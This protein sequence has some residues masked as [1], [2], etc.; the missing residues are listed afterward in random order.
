[1]RLICPNCGAQYEVDDAVIPDQGR[2]VQCSNCGHTWFQ[3]PAHKDQ[4]TADELADEVETGLAS[5]PEPEPEIDPAPDA[6]TP[7]Q[8]LDP[9]VAKL[10]RE[11]AA[12]E[13]AARQ[14]DAQSGLETQPDLGLDEAAEAAAARTAAARARMARMRGAEEDPDAPP[15]PTGPRK[16][17]LPDVEEINSSLRASEER[18]APDVSSTFAPSEDP[19]T[20][21]EA[22][23]GG[24]GR[25]LFRTIVVL[26]LIALA[27]Y[28]FAPQIVAQIPQSEPILSQYVDA[29]NGLRAQVD[30]VIAQL[31][32]QVQNLIGGGSSEGAPGTEAPLSE[33]PEPAPAP[34]GE[35]PSQ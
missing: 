10:L 27:V 4:D 23:S 28:V 18:M 32:E 8:E 15:V 12:R 11:E 14:A 34:E 9:D 26:A 19:T 30:P 31:T 13:A 20:A 24:A 1:M 7:R 35:T 17:L 21:Q 33:A 3:H 2:D 16:E 22:R 5:D 29:V 25:L 6:S